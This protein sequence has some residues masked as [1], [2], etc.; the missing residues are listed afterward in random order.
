MNPHFYP[1]AIFLVSI[2]VLLF[3]IIRLKIN[4]FVSLLG[5]GLLTGVAIGM[6]LDEVTKQISTGFGQT[7]GSI[8]IVIG[9][10]IVLGNL[11]AEARATE[12]IATLLLR[13]VGK[14]NALL[15]VNLTGYL[16]CIPVFLN[17]VFI[18]YM[19]IL[20]DISR[21]TTLPLISLVTALLIGGFATHCLVMPTPGPLAVMGTLNLPSGQFIGWSLLVA[22]PPA[23]L[24]LV[25][26]KYLIK[27]P[28]MQ[29]AEPTGTAEAVLEDDRKKPSGGLSLLLL[30]FP[31]L[32]ILFGSVVSE[33]MPKGTASRQIIA[34]LGDKNV[35]MLL[36]V[37][38]AG[39]LLRPYF[40]KTFEE[41]I[42]ESGASAG[43]LT[44][45]VGA[46]G[47]FGAIINGSGIATA[48][49]GWL[50]SMNMSLLMLGFVLTA[51]LRA[52]QGSATVAA[53]T[54]SSIVAPMIAVAGANP[55]TVGLA[56]CCG[57]MCC[58]FP[59]DS[60]FWVIS[61]FSGMTVGQTLRA[62]TLV[63]TLSGFVG[64]GLTLLIDL[65]W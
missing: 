59:N 53:V 24:G 34:F 21:K 1:L 58:S 50:S 46:G 14:K 17:A 6:P 30:L 49:V 10:G 62:W 4:P 33:M 35:A 29:I 28:H 61:R 31:I 3:T 63:S 18:I 44:L 60:G 52:A 15:A 55:I 23:L 11:L 13:A 8:G 12:Q 54:T 36:G 57:S 5:V 32:L 20:R 37:I 19:P 22:L 9:L 38:L 64:M 48:L 40:R 25:A 42:S 16:I 51:I 2:T 7:L 43:L 47:S 41:L 27:M 65:T 26:A 39:V 56:I 45:I